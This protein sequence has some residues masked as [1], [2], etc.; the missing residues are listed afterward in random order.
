MSGKEYGFVE[1]FNEIDV[2]L[3]KEAEEDWEIGRQPRGPLRGL[4]RA[5]CAALCVSL[6]AL[7]LFQPQ[8]QAAVKGFTGWIARLWQTGKDLS[9]YTEVINKQK[10]AEGFTLCLDEVILSDNRIYAAVTIDTEYLEGA[11]VGA[12]YVTINGSDYPV[13]SVSDQEEDSGQLLGELAARHLYTFVLEGELPE[14]IADMEL[15][16]TAY[17]N[18]EDLLEGKN[19]AAFDFGFLTER[20]ELERRKVQVPMGNR[21]TLEDG[22]VIRFKSLTLTELDSRIEAELEQVPEQETGE[23]HFYDW[24]LEGRDSL[25]N[26]V[27]Y[28]CDM[29]SGKE[30]TFV[31]DIQGGLLP[32]IDSEWVELQFYLYEKVEEKDQQPMDT[33]EGDEIVME[34]DGSPVNRVD[35]GDPFRIDMITG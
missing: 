33:A 16:F 17:Q 22:S 4:A 6:G 14:T 7:C 28:F 27:W 24:Y 2:R 35:V 20:E 34:D 10:T 9:P 25:G 31:C 12:R 5:A 30:L 8:A 15:H 21:I 29:G 32:S 11:V 1:L 3:V 23:E 18:G 13:K 19:G 26:P